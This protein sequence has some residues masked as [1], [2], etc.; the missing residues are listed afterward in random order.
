MEKHIFL[1]PGTEYRGVALWM[2]NDKL[3]SEEIAR[4]LEGLYEA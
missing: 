1:D 4:Q 2:L 3:E